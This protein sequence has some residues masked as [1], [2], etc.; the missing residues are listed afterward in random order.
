MTTV[1]MI[2]THDRSEVRRFLQFP[3]QLYQRHPL[4]VPPILIDARVQLNRD[5][6]PFYEHSEADFFLAVSDGKDVGRI[7]LLENK[8]YNQYHDRRIAQFF[9]FECIED[10]EVAQALFERAF[11]WAKGRDL[12]QVLGPKYSVRWM[13]MAC[14]WR[15]MSI[16]QR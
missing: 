16:D 2:N 9:L 7:A 1:E 5:A 8:P 3:F 6:H 15:G 4:W 11:E 13:V 10:F 12:T 14:W